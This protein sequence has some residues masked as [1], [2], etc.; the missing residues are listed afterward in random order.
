[1]TA[2]RTLAISSLVVLT[3]LA[4]C[5]VGSRIPGLGGSENDML[6]RIVNTTGTTLDLTSSGQP[7]GGEGHVA[8]G[9]TSGCIRV[10]E[11]T[12]TLGLRQ[13]GATSDVASFAPTL[14]PRTSYTVVA[15][16]SLTGSVQ[17]ATFTNDFVPTT[18][19][20]GL[21]IMDVAPTLG[22]L[23]VYVTPR[24]GSLDAPSTA[25]I[26]F[27]SNTGFFDVNPGTSQVR[28]TQATTFNVVFDAG[29][30]TLQ[31]GQ[32]STLVISQPSGTGG[33]PVASLAP[34]C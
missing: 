14:T 20:A 23:D 15:F 30:I 18:G 13:A 17:T 21:R 24:N 9:A 16:T 22:S 12:T 2:R 28:F 27:G 5:D 26:G 31:P 33:A 29:T 10:S 3:A 7:V 4:G 8:P 11:G 25:S 19:L 34:A 1:M 6:L 32:L